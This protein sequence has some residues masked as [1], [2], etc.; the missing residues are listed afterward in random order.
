MGTALRTAALPAETIKDQL[1]MFAK[2]MLERCHKFAFL[3]CHVR[4]E[5]SHE[6]QG[7]ESKCFR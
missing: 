1:L 7:G 4:V 5:I 6:I 3:T 2:R